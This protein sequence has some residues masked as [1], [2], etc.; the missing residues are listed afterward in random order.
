ML[1]LLLIYAFTAP[2]LIVAFVDRLWLAIVIDIVSVQSY[3]VLNEVARDLEDPFVYPPNDLALCH[4]Q[5]SL[6]STCSKLRG[7]SRCRESHSQVLEHSCQSAISANTCLDC[8]QTMSTC[9]ADAV[10]VQ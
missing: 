10:P 4:I 8:Q 1:A 2:L 3:W 9:S 7:L 6:L 5:V